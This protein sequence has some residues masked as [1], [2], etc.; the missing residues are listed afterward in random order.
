MEQ[1]Y[2]KLCFYFKW[3]KII[4]GWSKEEKNSKYIELTGNG[5]KK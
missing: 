1:P 5:S 2:E 3:T 4:N